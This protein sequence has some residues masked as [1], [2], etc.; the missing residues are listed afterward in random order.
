MQ[1]KSLPRSTLV[2][3]EAL[4]VR[5]EKVLRHNDMGGEPG[6]PRASTPTSGVGTAASSP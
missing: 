2:G 5:A 1:V 6:R 3:R 4:A